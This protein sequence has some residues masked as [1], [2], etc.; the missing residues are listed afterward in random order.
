M[1]WFILLLVA[2]LGF[3]I[4]H[5]KREDSSSTSLRKIFHIII[6]LAYVPAL[7]HQCSLLYLATGIALA[8]FLMLE[9]FLIPKISQYFFKF[10]F[11]FRQS[12]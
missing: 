4:R 11:T 8:L 9:V 1:I 6:V 3:V 10:L 12:V 5:L 2:T 7:M